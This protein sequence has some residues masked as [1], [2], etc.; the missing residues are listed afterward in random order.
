MTN[1]ILIGFFV[2]LGI[3]RT[4]ADIAVF[5][6]V[7]AGMEVELAGALA[8]FGIVFSFAFAPLPVLYAAIHLF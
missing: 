8:G 3:G 5:E 2:L 7:E 1:F 6:A 4:A